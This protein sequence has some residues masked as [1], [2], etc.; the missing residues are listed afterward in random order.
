MRVLETAS[1]CLSFKFMFGFFFPD[2]L[3]GG[4]SVS[5]RPHWNSPQRARAVRP[6]QLQ[7]IHIQEPL[8]PGLTH[9]SPQV[10][11]PFYISMGR[12]WCG[13][14]YSTAFF[15]YIGAHS[16]K[17][18]FTQYWGQ[19]NCQS[20]FITDFVTEWTWKLIICSWLS[21]GLCLVATRLSSITAACTW[22]RLIWRIKSAL[23]FF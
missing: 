2:L 5:V 1:F 19:L 6:V 4:W 23:F 3:V 10:S 12:S 18:L 14:S 22:N 9:S 7:T 11:V 15:F 20:H 17:A 13:T 16:R 8:H 21:A